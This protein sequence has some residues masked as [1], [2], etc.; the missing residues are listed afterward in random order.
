M[1]LCCCCSDL[2]RLCP[3]KHSFNHKQCTWRV[4]LSF[5]VVSIPTCKVKVEKKYDPGDFAHFSSER[6]AMDE[7]K[8]GSSGKRP[9]PR[10]DKQQSGQNKRPKRLKCSPASA[11]RFALEEGLAKLAI[12]IPGSVQGIVLKALSCCDNP[13]PDRQVTVRCGV[14]E[15]A[16][17]VCSWCRHRS[18]CH[19][20][21][22]FIC[23][24]EFTLCGHECQR[25]DKFNCPKSG[26]ACCH[27]PQFGANGEPT[28]GGRD[29]ADAACSY[30]KKLF[31]LH[32][33]ADH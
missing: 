5:C 19:S 8:Q 20:C 21:D 26:L 30:C 24:K 16:R 15:F 23:P 10:K 1:P 11:L 6:H 13:V 22:K 17:V 31:C 28:C 27:C 32:C 4:Y 3:N 7:A 25:Y 29:P 33:L 12:P 18:M 9:R 14:C 2:P